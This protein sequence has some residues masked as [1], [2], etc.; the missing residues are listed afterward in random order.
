MEKGITL[1]GG[2]RCCMGWDRRLANDSDASLRAENITCVARGTGRV[3]ASVHMYERV[4]LGA[5]N[6]AEPA[7]IYTRVSGKPSPAGE[8]EHG[9]VR[10]TSNVILVLLFVVTSVALSS[11]Q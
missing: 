11:R 9:F 2:A 6:C 8:V 4:W 10:S 1:A 7:S 3:A 5:A